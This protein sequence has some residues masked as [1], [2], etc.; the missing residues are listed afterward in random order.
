MKSILTHKITL[1]VLSLAIGLLMGKF[2]FSSAKEMAT[3]EDHTQHQEDKSQIWTCSMHPQIR[4][5]EPGNCPICGMTLIPV[6]EVGDDPLN[7]E[8]SEEAMRLGEIQTIKVALTAPEKEILMQGKVKMDEREISLITSRFAGRIEKLYV[9]FTGMEVRKG[10]KLASIYSPELITAQKELFEA[11]KYKDANPMLYNAAR[12]KLKLWN[13]TGSQI[14]EIEKGGEPKQMIDIISPSSGIVLNRMATLG[15]YVKE[16]SKLFEIVDLSNVWIIFDAYE[17]DIPWLKI[18]DNIDFRINA[19]S[20]KSFQGKIEFIDPIV[21]NQTR[22]TSVRLSFH[23]KGKILKPEMF[24]EG[25]LT[26]SL[27]LKEPEIMVPKSAVMWTGKRSIV[28]V[29]L[30]EMERPTFQFRE[31][32]TGLDLGAFYIV[33]SGVEHNE[34][35]VVNGAFKVDA[36]A[37][38]AGKYSM[39]NQPESDTKFDINSEF[40]HNLTLFYQVYI[41]L[42]N[43]FVNSDNIMANE[44]SLTL[45]KQL[46]TLDMKLL[47]G[48][49]HNLWMK[50]MKTI[51][52]SL[53]AISTSNNIDQQRVEFKPLSESLAIIIE[54]FGL[55]DAI[56]YKD[57]CPMAV[58]DKG[59]FWLSEV[60]EIRNPYFG[61]KMLKCG[62]VKK[63]IGQRQ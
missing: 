3:A 46:E 1:I 38:L 6:D 30:P 25:N 59:A 19:I 24:V 40:K 4:Q 42:K 58:N 21:N 54:S 17:S 56:V 60:K 10:Q 18:G 33:E 22:T 15:E 27:P 28:Y 13:I 23:N 47:K 52:S 14:E 5:N 29:K 49:A 45:I 37:Q 53:R 8:M 50:E 39:M 35:V 36:A 55:H 34:E 31:I 51:E 16:G 57:Y 62:E 9:D 12:N 20:G 2:F 63:V 61:D 48:E 11:L 44:K 43:A 32:K 7:L 41:D 26:A